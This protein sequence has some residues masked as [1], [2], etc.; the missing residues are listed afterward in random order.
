MP[1][2]VSVKRF[3]VVV[4]AAILAAFYLVTP[5]SA[6]T[7]SVNNTC[8]SDVTSELNNFF[9]S[10][11]AGSTVTFDPGCYLLNAGTVVVTNSDTLT[12][13]ATGA[14]FKTTSAGSDG[15]RAMFR[16]VGG[17]GLVF[18]NG[19]FTGANSTGNLTDALQWQHGID[20]RGVNGAEIS[21]VTTQTLYG[22]SV[23]VGINGSSWS[24]NVYVHG[25]SF[26]KS[27]RQGVS[28]TAG[29]AVRLDANT[30]RD[31]GYDAV[32][33]EPNGSGTGATNVQVTNSDFGRSARPWINVL[34]FSGGGTVSD[35]TISG[36]T[37]TGQSLESNFVPASGQR[38]SNIK[39]INN[40]SDTAPLNDDPVVEG[41]S[42][43][44][45]TIT[46]NTQPG[47][48]TQTFGYA[49]TSCNVD[50]SGNTFPGRQAWIIPFSGCDDTTAPVAKITRP[51]DGATVVGQTA[52]SATAT[53]NTSVTKMEI[54]V[55]GKVVG[56]TASASIS[57]N[58]NFRKASAGSHTIVAKAYDGAA[59]VGT[60]T[61]TVR[62]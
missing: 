11:P 16:F 25:S 29:D 7:P 9:S 52:I 23:Y 54:L 39:F 45:L 53:D 57:V 58:Y 14:E 17:N 13:D 8:A 48:S 59:N 21:N 6:A 46:G 33:V 32:D 40:T 26:S 55:D 3:L 24:K 27:G 38:W 28:I 1:L 35:I 10:L 44:G 22:D 51:A 12:I 15:N 2:T 37:V 62:K 31:I 34:G 47:T 18:K 36:N 43:T 30:Y 60:A 20:L 41:Y 56:T 5:A 4:A 19:K 49:E 42:I 50:I 61:V